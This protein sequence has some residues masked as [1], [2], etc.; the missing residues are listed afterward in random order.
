MCLTIRI[1][2]N[3]RNTNCTARAFLDCVEKCTSDSSWQYMIAFEFDKKYQFR[4]ESD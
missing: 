4:I 1:Y 2:Q 3:L